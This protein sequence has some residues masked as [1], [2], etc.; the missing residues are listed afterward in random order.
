M[1]PPA[2]GFIVSDDLHLH[3]QSGRYL[4]GMGSCA[5]CGNVHLSVVGA[6]GMINGHALNNSKLPGD[7]RTLVLP[8]N[9]CMQ[10]SLSLE[11]AEQLGEHLRATVSEIREREAAA[12]AL[13]KEAVKP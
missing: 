2:K 4:L 8:F 10:L 12:R 5:E 7:P 6:E 9:L 13:A 1:S 3:D 11:Q